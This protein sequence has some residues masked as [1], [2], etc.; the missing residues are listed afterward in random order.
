MASLV[1]LIMAVFLVTGVAYGI[2]ART[3]TTIDSALMR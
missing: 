3:I 1:F 2:G